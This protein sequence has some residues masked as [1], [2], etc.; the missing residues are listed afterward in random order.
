[1]KALRPLAVALALVA[2]ACSPAQ[3]E[4]AAKAEGGHT[5]ISFATDW[6]AQAEQGG[7]YQALAT[8]EYAK[9][10]LDVTIKQGGPGVN[11]PQLLA[12]GAVDL[13]MGSNSFIVLNLA[14]EQ[15]PVRAVAAFMQKDPQVLIAHD[16]QGIEGIADLKGHP[17]LLS[18]ASVT[19]FWVWLKAKYG[20]TDDQVR[21]YTFNSAPFLADKKVAQQGYVTS[22]PYTLETEAKIKPKVFLLADNGYPGYAALVLAPDSLIAK[23]PAAVKAFVE[24]SAAGWESY[25]HG[26]PK[27]GDALILKDNPEMTQDVLDQAREKMRAYKLVDGGDGVGAMTDARWK[28][29]FDM[30]AGQGVYDKAMDY[31]R[32][33]D[34]QF[35][36][37]PKAATP[38]K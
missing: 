4:D 36:G 26:D 16:G 32:A 14:R 31:K 2:A 8:G 6:R 3:K 28:E 35:L 29:F 15:A 33:Y 24:A 23:N 19:A 17:I 20:F 34:L 13:G 7:F 25:L 27:P 21:K 18:D 30:A 37:A 5:A 10:G 9:R 38:A 12:A 1:M 11:V 22:E